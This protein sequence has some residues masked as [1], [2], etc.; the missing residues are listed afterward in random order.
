MVLD[1]SQSV[2]ISFLGTSLDAGFNEKRK[3]RW[4]PNVGIALANEPKI[5]RLILLH[6]KNHVALAEQVRNDALLMRH[7][8][9]VELMAIEADPFELS[10][11]FG[12]VLQLGERLAFN[13]DNRYYLNISTGTH[14]HQISFFMMAESKRWPVKLVQCVDAK[15]DSLAS[16]ILVIDL[17]LSRYD[18]V[19][20]RYPVGSA[21]DVDR[22]KHN[23]PTKNA[24]Y[25]QLIEKIQKVALRSR[26]PILLTGPTGA[27]KTAMARLLHK[28]KIETGLLSGKFVEVNC[29][30]LRGDTV[31][32][33]L[34][35]HKKGSFTGALS[36][37]DG[38]LK[39]ADKGLLFLDEIGELGLS[40]QAML[41]HAI[42]DKIF[43]PLGS[44]KA[45]QSDFQLIAGTNRDLDQLVSQGLFREDLLARIDTWVF[46]M[47]SLRERSEDIDP[48]LD[49]ELRKASNPLPADRRFLA[50]A[51]RAYLEFAVSPEAAWSGNFRDL[52][53][54][55][56]RM[57]TLSKQGVID[58]EVVQDEIHTLKRKW[59]GAS[60]K[61]VAS[62]GSQ[63]PEDLVSLV[64]PDHSLNLFEHNQLNFVLRHS[65]DCPSY[66]ALSRLLY[67]DKAGTNAA[68][69]SRAYLLGYGLELGSAKQAL[70]AQ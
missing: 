17:D 67:G 62:E 26:S 33:T 37:R 44:E 60:S 54:S 51:R 47:P 25:N 28:T 13:P 23:I 14:I 42:E 55:V 32:S 29:S 11:T 40:E 15:T 50:P 16:R 46:K 8:F 3:A 56:E 4:R 49:Y 70:A 52:S 5:D 21:D 63:I 57:I 7:D 65:L 1:M 36:D 45:I 31:M 9:E 39:A 2:M 59:K 27:G 43:T 38:L 68:Q 10:S 35:G 64:L 30:T 20:N 22:L 41:L 18:Q 48:N 66:A 19:M 24:L 6:E 69:K 34:F 53:S 61:E 58:E 12:M